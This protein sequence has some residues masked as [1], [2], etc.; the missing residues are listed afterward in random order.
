MTG[1]SVATATLDLSGIEEWL[2]R[3]YRITLVAV[4]DR[5]QN[6]RMYPCQPFWNLEAWAVNYGQDD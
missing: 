3:E 5:V 2:L 1:Y 4:R 6:T